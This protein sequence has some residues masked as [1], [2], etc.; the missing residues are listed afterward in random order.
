M[1]K[2]KKVAQLLSLSSPTIARSRDASQNQKFS[3]MSPKAA[4]V[5]EVSLNFG[6]LQSLSKVDEL[7]HSTKPINTSSIKVSMNTDAAVQVGD[8][9]K[10]TLLLSANHFTRDEGLSTAKRAKVEVPKQLKKILRRLTHR[11]P[12]KRMTAAALLKDRWITGSAGGKIGEA[13][14]RISN[15]RLQSKEEREGK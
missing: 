12:E 3:F 13:V 11:K 8:S 7:I 1:I 9:N 10:N 4:P 15:R 5:E 6:N 14:K 2:T